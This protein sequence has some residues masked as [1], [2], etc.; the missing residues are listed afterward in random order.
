MSNPVPVKIEGLPIRSPNPLILTTH[1]LGPATGANT[2]NQTLMFTPDY[3]VRVTK[4]RLVPSSNL[5]AN[6]SSVVF[7]L[8]TTAGDV[9]ATGTDVAAITAADGL[10]LTIDATKAARPTNEKVFFRAVG[11]AGSTAM[12]AITLNVQVEYQPG[13]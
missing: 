8:R 13:N 5:P 10:L 11:I 3:P 12:D 4:V 7:S 2:V 1:L 6:A 9:I